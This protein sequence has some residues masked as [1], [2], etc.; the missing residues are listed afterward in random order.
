MTVLKWCFLVIFLFGM[1][2]IAF[3]KT[4]GFESIPRWVGYHTDDGGSL[5]CVTDNDIDLY[6]FNSDD[7]MICRIHENSLFC[8]ENASLEVERYL[9]GEA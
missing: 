9:L 3:A 6:C 5:H 8:A 1:T 4:G 7:A 2:I